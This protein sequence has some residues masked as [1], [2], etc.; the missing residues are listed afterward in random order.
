MAAGRRSGFADGGRSAVEYAAFDFVLRDAV[1][2]GSKSAAITG[3]N[4]LGFGHFDHSDAFG[5]VHGGDDRRVDGHRFK[6]TLGWYDGNFDCKRFLFL[7]S[8][9]GAFGQFELA[10]AFCGG[11]CAASDF[12]HSHHRA[13][14][15]ADTPID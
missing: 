7:T 10:D 2:V 8:E 12:T 5:T 6:D 4:H 11:F 9:S 15:V 14:G 13:G 3:G 1:A